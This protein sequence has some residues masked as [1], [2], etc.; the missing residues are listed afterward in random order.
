[1]P[2]TG[3]DRLS[4]REF[5]ILGEDVYF[6]PISPAELSQLDRKLTPAEQKAVDDYQSKQGDA[7]LAQERAKGGPQSATVSVTPQG[8]IIKALGQ[9]PKTPSDISM[10]WMIAIPLVGIG[11]FLL[12]RDR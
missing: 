3:R 7:D 2:G 10:A 1:M 5:E 9:K 6:G 12:L 4:E 8:A 11:L